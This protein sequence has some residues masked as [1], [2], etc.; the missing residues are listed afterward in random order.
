MEDNLKPTPLVE[1]EPIIIP[2]AAHAIAG[3]MSDFAAISRDWVIHAIISRKVFL[4]SFLTCHA[5]IIITMVAIE[6]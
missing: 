3:T 6:E 5:I 2:A 4:V 1:R